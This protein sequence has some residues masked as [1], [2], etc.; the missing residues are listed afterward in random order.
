M[1][2]VPAVNISQFTADS[3]SA[4]SRVDRRTAS[5]VCDDYDAVAVR[6]NR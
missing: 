3:A 1:I 4:T 5:V 2:D 6:V